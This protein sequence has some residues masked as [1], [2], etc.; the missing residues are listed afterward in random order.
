M[1]DLLIE[2]HNAFAEFTMEAKDYIKGNKS[3]GRRSRKFGQK[4]RE[5]LK[6]WRKATITEKQHVQGAR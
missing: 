5:L 1:D 6:Q 3:A 2:I 4:L